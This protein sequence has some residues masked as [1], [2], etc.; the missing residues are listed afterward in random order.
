MGLGCHVCSLWHLGGG[1]SYRFVRRGLPHL[2]W[3]CSILPFRLMRCSP[4]YQQRSKHQQKRKL[5]L[6][7]GQSF[8]KVHR[9]GLGKDR[10]WRWI[11]QRPGCLRIS[12]HP[13]L[14]PGR[15]ERC[16]TV[17]PP[18]RHRLI[19]PN[20]RSSRVLWP[21]PSQV[22]SHPQLRRCV[23]FLAGAPTHRFLNNTFPRGR[24]RTQQGKSRSA[25][26]RLC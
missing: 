6:T 17:S 16:R 10:G 2:P 22:P 11:W 24:I 4:N 1:F 13:T 23:C 12:W 3:Q 9:G 8:Q 21:T 26:I 5:R 20:Q 19:P 7:L 14:C 18:C 15:T 25:F